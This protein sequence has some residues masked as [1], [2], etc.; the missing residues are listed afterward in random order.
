[1]AKA[2]M[3]H[4]TTDLQDARLLADNARLRAR[5]GEL[6]ALVLQLSTENDRLVAQA[7]ELIGSSMEQEM[8]PA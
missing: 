1:M 8:Q 2:L 7:A 3:G 6:E 5:V 4:L